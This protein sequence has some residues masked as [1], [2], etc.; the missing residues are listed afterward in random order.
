MRPEINSNICPVQSDNVLARFPTSFSTGLGRIPNT[1][2]QVQLKTVPRPVVPVKIDA[3]TS[4]L[5]YRATNG[6][7]E[8]PERGEWALL[9]PKK[10]VNI[11]AGDNFPGHVISKEGIQSSSENNKSID[12][13]KLL[14]TLANV[15]VKLM[16][17]P[18]NHLNL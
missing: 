2:H 17:I 11:A 13:K 18:T 10:F 1:V 16:Y 4:P 14:P 5:H 8:P 6:L 3:V 15:L 7:K 12:S 9:N